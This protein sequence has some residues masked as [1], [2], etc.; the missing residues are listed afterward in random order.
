MAL[1]FE[2][3]EQLQEQ[4][5]LWL[6]LK[7]EY[8]SPE[9]GA[10]LEQAEDALAAL[11]SKAEALPENPA[12]KALE[13][14]DL[15][16]I[17]S[18]RP[19]GP[20]TL[21]DGISDADLD[22]QI[23][24]AV[25]ARFAACVLGVPVECFTVQEMRDLALYSGTP[26]PPTEYWHGTNHGDWIQYDRSPRTSFL[27][28]NMTACPADDDINYTL[29][30]LE[31]MEKYGFGFTTGDIAEYWKQHL[32]FTAFTAEL[33]VLH[34]LADGVEPLRA[35]DVNNPY[36]QYIGAFIR[37]DPWAYA[38]AGQPEKAAEFA[39]RDAFLTH[40]RN[41]IYGE[42]YFAAAQAAAFA[43]RNIRQ[44]L[45]IG[46]TEIPA[47]CTLAKDLRWALE[48]A[49]AFTDWETGRKLVDERFPGL[50]MVHTNNNA[51]LVIFALL[52]CG[53][54][55]TKL[56]SEIVAMGLD[57]DC[58]AAT[59]GSIFGAVY[60]TKAIPSC[61]TEPF[62]DTVESYIAGIPTMKISDVSARFAKLA[63]S[64]R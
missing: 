31:I 6:E 56:A 64:N 34:N 35:A 46:L 30:G 59:A 55:F 63:R 37:S 17:R 28:Q 21:L 52:H 42:M 58:T 4:L 20:R 18:L 38:C 41:G 43:T 60:G 8:R 9:A 16:S 10:L 26:F 11:A 33:A 22:D 44:A 12:L 39:W 24:A 5:R 61:W 25:N 50:N 53:G 19:Q 13:P 29:V 40:R 2:R 7:Q 15:D 27:K 1:S 54:D 62:H 47:E 49:D 36:V 45:E 51:C 23:A 3:L 14:D 57:N 32:G 48:K